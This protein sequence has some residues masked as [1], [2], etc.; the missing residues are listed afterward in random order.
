LEISDLKGL[1]FLD[2]HIALLSGMINV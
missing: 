1:F 2:N